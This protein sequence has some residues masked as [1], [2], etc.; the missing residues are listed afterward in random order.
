MIFNNDNDTVVGI[1]KNLNFL[2][3]N[4]RDQMNI[5][6]FPNYFINFY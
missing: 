2:E 4:K 1:L 6:F 5:H 3:Y